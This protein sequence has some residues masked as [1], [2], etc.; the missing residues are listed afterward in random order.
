MKWLPFSRETLVSSKSKEEILERLEAVTQV[1]QPEGLPEIRPFF[2]GSVGANGFRLSRAIDKGDNFLPL[3]IGTVED[4]PRG[5]IIFVRYRLF[6][7]T[8]FFLWF[9]TAILLCF[10][11][12][13]FLVFQQ[14]LQ[15]GVCLFLMVVNY[16]LVVFFFHRQ[17]GTSKKLFQEVISFP[18]GDVESFHKQ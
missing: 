16:A 17:L 4:T 15:G 11:I 1:I 5:S 2:Y 12:F 10:S 8:L 6:A 3:V 7:S 13:F 9:W 18:K 14:S